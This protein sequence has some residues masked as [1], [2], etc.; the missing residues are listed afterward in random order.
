[1]SGREYE[2]GA[3]P[4]LF[5]FSS[6]KEAKSYHIEI[7]NAGEIEISYLQFYL[8]YPVLTENGSKNNPYKIE[9]TTEQ[10]K[11]IKLKPGESVTYHIY[12]PIT[13]VF[14]DP[15]LLDLEES[16]QSN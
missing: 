3:Q 14:G 13:K 5:H 6:E 15:N 7:T 1:M 10:H 8:H 16:L 9:A 2:K 12:A 11:P 4:I